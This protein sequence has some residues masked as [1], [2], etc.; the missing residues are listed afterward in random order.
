M[1]EIDEP[2]IDSLAES[3]RIAYEW[4]NRALPLG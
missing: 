3:H 4:G 2:S 1:I